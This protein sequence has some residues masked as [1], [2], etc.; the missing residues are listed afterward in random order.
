MKAIRKIYDKPGKEFP[1]LTD[2]MCHNPTRRK[3]GCTC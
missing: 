3:D 2:Y 1:L